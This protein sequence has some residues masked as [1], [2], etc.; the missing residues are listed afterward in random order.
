M[1]TLYLCRHAKSS[2]ADPGQ[3]DHER[4]LN[5]RG[6][7]DAPDMAQ[8]FHARG[9]QLHLIVSSDAARAQ[10]TARCFF[11]ELGMRPDRFALE[12]RLYH[13][14]PA[15]IARIVSELPDHSAHV[16]LFGHNPGFSEA[17][18]YFT[19]DGPGA[20]PTCGLVRID[21][22]VEHWRATGRDLGTL[23]WFDCPKQTRE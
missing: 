5:E 23:A 14:S 17:V 18:E 12:P 10:A 11:E 16:M 20:L 7:R 8:R 19:G 6:L 21:F 9:E 1:R 2:W 4:P 22:P 15:T 13:A 3:S